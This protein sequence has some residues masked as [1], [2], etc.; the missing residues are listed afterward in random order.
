M[1]N[2]FTVYLPP[3]L[4]RQVKD[5][6]R[7]EGPPISF[8]IREGLKMV[9]KKRNRKADMPEIGGGAGLR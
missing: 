5:F 2:P 6:S 7:R 4:Y 1:T 3:D 9:L 8:L